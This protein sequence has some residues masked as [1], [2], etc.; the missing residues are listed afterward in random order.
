MAPEAPASAPSATPPAPVVAPAVAP[1]E[2]TPPAEPIKKPDNREVSTD[3]SG[4]PGKGFTAKFGDKFSSNLR[5]RFQPRA[6]LHV[7]PEVD[8]EA[9]KDQLV[10]IGTARVWISGHAYKPELTYMLQLALAGRD[11]RDGLTSP[12][13][14]AYI[15]YKAHPNASIRVGQFFVPF[16]RLRTVREFAL[17]LADRPRPVGELTL[18]RDVGVIVYSDAVGGKKSP[19][20]YRVGLFGGGGTNLST[21]KKVG[22]L[23]TARVEYRPLGEIDDDSEGDLKRRPK[24]AIALGIGGATNR[25][26]NRARSTT[27]TTY[28]RGNADYWHGV[29]DATVKWKGWALQ[30]EYLIKKAKEDLLSD[31]GANSEYARS[32]HGWV[33]QTSYVFAT[34]VEIVGR[35]SRLG[36]YDGTDPKLLV[37]ARTL[38]QEFATGVNYYL[39]GHAAKLQADWI[40]RTDR[41]LSFDTKDHT[42]HVQLDVTF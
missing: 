35:V 2:V 25:N 11:Y 32:G 29:L 34:P 17:Q 14:D 42:F 18:D 5:I 20:A 23:V 8:G 38:G 22:G 24:P 41:D 39:N 33:A 3:L 19:I 16:D 15:D 12:I 36:A 37:E 30:L 26:T 27:G 28:A 13:F 31:A 4:V 9:K 40:L 21:A 10:N 6:Q 7:A 1:V